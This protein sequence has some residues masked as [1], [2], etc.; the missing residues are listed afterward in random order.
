MKGRMFGILALV[1]VLI[2]LG[3]IAYSL[4]FFLSH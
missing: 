2:I 1:G 3:G 4:A